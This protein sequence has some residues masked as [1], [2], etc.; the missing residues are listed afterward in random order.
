MNE[1]SSIPPNGPSAQN[2]IVGSLLLLSCEGIAPGS[3]D[4]PWYF[5][6]ELT[7]VGNVEFIVE[8]RPIFW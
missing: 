2:D 5:Q 1:I 3:P 4:D 7:L 6:G 8:I